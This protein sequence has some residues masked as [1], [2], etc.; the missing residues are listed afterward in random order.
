MSQRK[1]KQTPEIATFLAKERGRSKKF[2]P[3]TGNRYRHA[4][5]MNVHDL[6]DFDFDEDF[7]ETKEND[8][9]WEDKL[10]REDVDPDDHA[11]EYASMELTDAANPY[12]YPL[13][14]RQMNYGYFP[15]KPPGPPPVES[16]PPSIEEK[17]FADQVRYNINN[18]ERGGKR[19]TSKKR[20]SRSKKSSK[21]KLSRK[22]HKGNR[23]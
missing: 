7:G 8:N 4:L 22:Q 6:D 11:M 5:G 17:L 18:E 9:K 23:K 20:K 2:T 14:M 19:K 16:L 21:K 15:Q 12:G 10:M 3:D 1:R 13:T